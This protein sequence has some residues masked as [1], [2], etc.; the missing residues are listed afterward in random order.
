MWDPTDLDLVKP[1]FEQVLADFLRE[2]CQIAD[3]AGCK[4][5]VTLKVVDVLNANLLTDFPLLHFTVQLV[6][7]LG[8][9]TPREVA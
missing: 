7:E 4:Q 5:T 3:H 9:P 1:L 6:E 8:G 2:R